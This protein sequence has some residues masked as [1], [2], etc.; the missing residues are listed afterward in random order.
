MYVTVSR[1]ITPPPIFRTIRRFMSIVGI[2]MTIM[3]RTVTIP[4]GNK[5]SGLIGP[6][7]IGSLSCGGK[8]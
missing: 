2:G 3:I 6:G 5:I 1:I 8:V 7:R 4:T